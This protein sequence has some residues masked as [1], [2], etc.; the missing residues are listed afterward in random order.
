MGTLI[1]FI[2]NDLVRSRI[3]IAYALMLALLSIGLFNLEG[4][5]EKALLTLVNVILL[6]VPLMAILF[7][8]VHFHNS[9]EFFELLLS[10]PLTRSQIFWSELIALSMALT[11]AFLLGMGLPIL[12]YSFNSIGLWVI[13]IGVLIGLVFIMLACLAA[14]FTRDK[15]RSIGMVVIMWLYFALLFDSLVLLLLYFFSD[16]PMEKAMLVFSFLN[17]IDLGRLFILLKMN[18]AAIMGFTAAVFQNFLG[19][20]LGTILALTILSLW[21][22]LPAGLATFIFNKRDI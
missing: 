3:L 10:Q 11:T 19:S 5:Q 9:Y 20:M 12:I 14:V 7:S 18:T 6:A 2:L 4:Q 17:P 21:I 13:L 15:T 22:L 8:T 16:Y 1:K